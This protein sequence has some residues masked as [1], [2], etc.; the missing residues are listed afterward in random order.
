MRE[1]LDEAGISYKLKGRAPLFEADLTGHV[2]IVEDFITLGVDYIIFGP[3][4]PASQVSAIMSA[5]KAGIPIMI[6][7]HLTPGSPSLSK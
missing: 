2:E 6:M 1:V 5:N 7:N 4:D 3:I